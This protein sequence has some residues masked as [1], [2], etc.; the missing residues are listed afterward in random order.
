MFIEIL[1]VLIL[2]SIWLAFYQIL[3]QQGRILLRLD[4]LE[5][6][7][8]Y[9]VLPS[10]LQG[11]EVGTQ[12]PEFKLHDLNGKQVGLSEYRG[13]R[14]LLF[15]WSPECGF[16]DLAAPDLA[17]AQSRLD[18]NGIQL[19]LLAYG[20]LASNRKLAEEHG[21]KCPILL[22]KEDVVPEPLAHEGTPSAY[23]LDAEGRVAH[24]IAVGSGEITAL[25]EEI[26]PSQPEPVHRL[27]DKPLSQSKIIRDGLK[28]GTPAPGFTLPDISGGLVS[29]DDFRDR[30]LLLVF[31]DPHCGPCDELAPKLARFHREHPSDGPAVVLVG[32]G[33]LEEN[34]NKARQHGL[35]FPVVLQDKWKLSREYGIFATPVAFLIDANGVIK[36]D[37]AV[38]LDAILNLVQQALATAKEEEYE[39]SVR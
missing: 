33:D 34:R 4:A 25:L 38:G 24:S 2:L 29:L 14:V 37:V 21:L 17:R 5:Q 10:Q 26:L 32:R 31:S 36:H 39:L 30:E 22:Y 18:Q 19:L 3:K 23:L 13:K 28:A 15:H 12:F 7:Q 11:L 1:L 27:G 35:E 9:A 20:D 8:H 16:C 6:Q